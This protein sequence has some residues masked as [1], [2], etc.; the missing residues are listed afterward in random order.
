MEDIDEKESSAPSEMSSDGEDSVSSDTSLSVGERDIYTDDDSNDDD[1]DDDDLKEVEAAAEVTAEEQDKADEASIIQEEKIFSGITD[2]TERILSRHVQYNAINNMIADRRSFLVD[3]DSLLLNAVGQSGLDSAGGGQM[4]HCVYLC[5]RLLQIFARVSGTF[6]IVFSKV[7]DRIL[8]DNHSIRLAR[9]VLKHHFRHN[10]KFFVHEIE[11]IWSVDF[12]QIL[13]HLR[14]S[15]LLC[16]ILPK[17]CS[18]YFSED[19]YRWVKVMSCANIL[20]SIGQGLPCVDFR[21]ITL[22]VSTIHAYFI[23]VVPD[24]NRLLQI[25]SRKLVNITKDWNTLKLF[26]QIP[27]DLISVRRIVYIASAAKYLTFNKDTDAM[28]LVKILLLKCAILDTL[29]LKFRAFPQP[30]EVPKEVSHF[31]TEIHKFMHLIMENGL[32]YDC[33]FSTVSDI[34]QGNLFLK[35]LVTLRNHV[36]EQKCGL[37]DVLGEIYVHLTA[38][39]SDLWGS[40]LE[41]FPITSE[42]LKWTHKIKFVQNRDSK[43]NTDAAALAQFDRLLP[44]SCSLTKEFC[45][46]EVLNNLARLQNHAAEMQL[47]ISRNLDF[48]ERHHWHSQKKLTDDFS[49]VFDDKKKLRNSKGGKYAEKKAQKHQARF[50]RYMNIYGSNLEGRLIQRDIIVRGTKQN[51]NTASVVKSKNYQKRKPEKPK[52]AD[53]IRKQNNERKRHQ[54]EDSDK[55]M[56]KK[57]NAK[58]KSFLLQFKFDIALQELQLL[59]K[60]LKTDIFELETGLLMAETLHKKLQFDFR[61]KGAGSSH[62]LE[63]YKELFLLLRDLLIGSESKY[64]LSD[65]DKKQIAYYLTC[66]N[67]HDISS[68]WNLPYVQNYAKMTIIDIKMTW[69]E[70][71]LKHLGPSLIRKNQG[72]IDDELGFAPDDWQKMLI[73][74]VRKRQSAIVVAPTSSGKTYASYYCMKSVLQEGHEGIVVYV[75]PTKALVNQVA[76][77]VYARFKN[78][79]MPPGLSVYGIFTRDYRENAL[80]CQ[81]LV[82]VPECLEILLLSPRMCCW[83]RRLRYIIF[84]E[85]HCLSGIAGGLSWE[86]GL[87]LTRCPFLALSATVEQP[88]ILQRWLQESMNFKKDRDMQ[89]GCKQDDSHYVVSLITHNERHNDLKKYIY[90]HEQNSLVHVHPYAFLTNKVIDTYSGIPSHLTL[91]AEETLSLFAALQATEQMHTNI[92]HLRPERFFRVNSQKLF[93]TRSSVKEYEKELRELLSKWAHE[94]NDSFVS[95]V[96]RLAHGAQNLRNLPP[97]VVPIFQLPSLIETLEKNKMFPA[98]VFLFNRS[99]I[100]IFLSVLNRYYDAKTQ[101]ILGSSSDDS[102]GISTAAET[103]TRKGRA[104]TV[105]KRRT[106]SL[107]LLKGNA[108]SLRSVGV[109]DSDDLKFIENRLIGIGHKKDDPFVKGLRNGIGIHHAGLNS[110]E[111]VTV[112]MM[113]RMKVLNVVFATSTLALGIHMPCKTVVIAT[114]SSFLTPLNYHQMSGRAG[115]RGFDAEGNVVFWGVNESRVQNLLTGKL[116]ILWGNF[117]MSISLVLRLLLL[118]SMCEVAV[119]ENKADRGSVQKEAVSRALTFLNCNLIYQHFPELKQQMK[120]FFAFSTQLLMMQKLLDDNGRPQHLCSGIVTH[121]HYHEPGNLVFAYL[122]RSG[123]LHSMCVTEEDGKISKETQLNVVLLMAHLFTR[124][125]LHPAMLNNKYCNSVVK[126]KELPADVVKVIE[127]YNSEVKFLF[128]H[129]FRCV[130]EECSR[131]MGEDRVLPISQLSIEPETSCME[132]TRAENELPHLLQEMMVDYEP[133]VICSAFIALS[134]YTDSGLYSEKDVVSNLRHQVFTDKKI[135]PI[136]EVDQSLNSYAWDF[137]NHGIRKAVL[138]ENLIRH[139]DDFTYLKDFLLVLLAVYTSLQDSDDAD[140]NG[141]VIRTFGII[142]ENFRK[143]FNKAYK[144]VED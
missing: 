92:E 91:S 44:I 30:Y 142:S 11:A 52:M 68:E 45:G 101:G 61:E 114:D 22:E 116:P 80:T 126:L 75:S 17:E 103:K 69:A 41:S 12:R 144:I 97:K 143:K 13:K 99:L 78:V 28:L 72:E 111:R 6:E 74:T 9:S 102:D 15:F 98:I 82:T 31:I 42:G 139:G 64:K 135:V 133:R 71:Q 24:I 8:K 134:G 88:E 4:L 109:V 34:W 33:C 113:F 59:R 121:L 7:W 36:L 50:A 112:E 95:V 20:Y 46:E 66:L 18:S 5:E 136:F 118:V 43:P 141:A 58:I 65:E 14:P 100:H 62:V 37:G 138:K 57:S 67:M 119:P 63:L 108:S 16:D 40:T 115:R 131:T 140:E 117:P 77:T 84:D 25:I 127:Q 21:N 19:N 70:F 35:L 105:R 123:V 10:T 53:I 137:Y 124:K 49:R 94:F 106:Y 39:L 3:G 56:F 93:I 47:F 83:V 76:A 128:D 2:I 79:T 107:G 27:Q 73:D 125:R 90:V 85:I 86:S 130:A 96:S 29:P 132:D 51:N 129:Y 110:K 122:L 38:T 89:N 87:L 48:E 26:I 32:T 81:I 104:V 23:N 120:H 1:G 55:V 60:N 54:N